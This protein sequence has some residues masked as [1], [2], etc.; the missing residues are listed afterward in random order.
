MNCKEGTRHLCSQ[1]C[2]LLEKLDAPIYAQPV[3]L[4]NGTSIGQHF[5]HILDFYTSVFKGIPGGIIDFS[6]RERSPSVEQSPEVAAAAFRQIIN[7]LEAINPQEKIQV[8]ADFSSTSEAGRPL[9]HSSIARELMFA[10]DHAVHHMAMIRIGI[11]HLLP[12]FYLDEA[13]GL[14]PA[15]VK[16]RKEGVVQKS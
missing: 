7:K 14:A 10:Y 13:F 6:K 15:T 11:Q 4:F 8:R 2:E 1:I 12:E 9:I 5:R 3:S 16:Y